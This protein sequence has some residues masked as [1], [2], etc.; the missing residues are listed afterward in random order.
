MSQDH[1]KEKIREHY[2][3]MTPYY[4]DLWGEHIHHGYWIDGSE[5]RQRAQ[6]QLVEYLAKVAGIPGGC[7]ILDVGCGVGASSIYLAQRYHA[8][9]VGITISPVQVEMAKR[10]AALQ[11]VSAEFLLV[12]AEAMNFD[13]CFDVLWSIE[14]VSHYQDVRRFFGSATKLLKPGGILA[15]TDWFKR[16]GLTSAEEKNYI[17]PIE[18]SML[19]N[20]HALKDY[21]GWLNENRVCIQSCEVLNQQC[22]RTWD[23]CLEI[24]KDKKLWELAAKHSSQFVTYLR[25]FR[26]MRAGFASGKFIYG[27]IVARKS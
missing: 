18:R 26:A 11:N 7:K 21:C 13:D 16:D 22:A 19:V 9:V 1:H 4:H 10:A 20:L 8:H 25:G 17:A 23:I 2:D 6:L 14:S 24:I 3:V 5:T 15:I 12:D 27:L